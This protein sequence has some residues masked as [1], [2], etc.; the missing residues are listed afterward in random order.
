MIGEVE[1]ML[2]CRDPDPVF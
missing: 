2:H 1:K